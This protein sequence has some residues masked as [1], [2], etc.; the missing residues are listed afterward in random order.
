MVLKC[1]KNCGSSF[2]SN[3][4]LNKHLAQRIPCNSDLRKY[5]CTNDYCSHK[6]T[7]RQAKSAHM[8][9]CK[10]KRTME[11]LTRDNE[12]L[13]EALACVGKPEGSVV[14]TNNGVINNSVDNSIDNSLTSKYQRQLL[15]K[16]KQRVHPENDSRGYQ[17]S[18]TQ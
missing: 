10:P 16:R 4:N 8:K 1:P 17:R 2:D 14:H 15:W 7:S 3:S 18:S 12:H 6:F 5:G 11:T 9:T 13:R